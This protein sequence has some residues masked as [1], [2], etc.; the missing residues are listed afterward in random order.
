[1]HGVGVEGIGLEADAGILG[2]RARGSNGERR[3]AGPQ[4]VSVPEEQG[5][6]VDL[7]EKTVAKYQAE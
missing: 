3:A 2:A 5:L 4:N 1:V 7:D 6:G